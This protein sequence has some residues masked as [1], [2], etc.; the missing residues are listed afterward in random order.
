MATVIFIGLAFFHLHFILFTNRG[1]QEFKAWLPRLQDVR[2]LPQ[3]I[4]YNLGLTKEHPRFDR[5][6][7]VEK[8]EYW[9]LMWGTLVM[10]V[11]GLALWAK[12]FV[13][14]YIPKWGLDVFEVIHYY[15]AWLATLAIIVWHLYM[16]LMRPGSYSSSWMWLTGKITRE[17]MIEEHPLEWERMEREAR[18]SENAEKEEAQEVIQPARST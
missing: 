12:T 10:V 6:S 3:M 2:D 5:F 11:T 14:H 7:Y 9:A 16:V 18:S 13:L 4:S 1:R 8:M 15:E 17:E